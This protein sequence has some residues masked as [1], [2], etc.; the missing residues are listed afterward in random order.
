MKCQIC[1]KE[2]EGKITIRDANIDEGLIVCGDCL[3]DF[4]NQNYDKLTKK[5]EK[6]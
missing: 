3:N 2:C 6:R 1:N 5:L 4:G